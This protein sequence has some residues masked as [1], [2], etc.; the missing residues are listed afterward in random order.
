LGYSAYPRKS[1]NSLLSRLASK[2][3][4]ADGACM[5]EFLIVARLRTVGL[6]RRDKKF[7][8]HSAHQYNGRA[9]PETL[10]RRI[11]A[12]SAGNEN[13]FRINILILMQI[14]FKSKYSF[15]IK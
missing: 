3:R 13:A 10:R 8:N 12:A 2:A 4:F 6:F 1:L 7:L 11:L 9:F 15:K 5:R 14:V